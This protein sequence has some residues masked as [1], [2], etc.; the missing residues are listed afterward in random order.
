MPNQA[1]RSP[2]EKVSEAIKILLRDLGEDPE[3]EG[4]KLTPQRVWKAMHEM[5]RGYKDD[6]AK[7]LD[8]IFIE[9]FDQMIVVRGIRFS[10]LCEHHMLPFT[11]S[12]AVGY[13]PSEV[14]PK[15]TEPAAGWSLAQR[16]FEAS[17]ASA[18]SQYRIVGLSKIPRLV[19]C[20]A[21]R[22]QL[23]ERLTTQIADALMSKPLRAAGAGVVI[24]A[25]HSCMGC[26]GVEQADAEM[27]TSAMLGVMRESPG[28]KAEL[29]S[30]L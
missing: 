6:P 29:L 22:L 16:E 2:S 18:P 9:K 7:I 4:L 3:R 11:G 17:I 10:S 27:V 1:S 26:R 13:I 23:Q 12:V 8:R 28:A 21:R 5:C 14:S 19:L 20:F 25:H 24:K 15:K 30:L